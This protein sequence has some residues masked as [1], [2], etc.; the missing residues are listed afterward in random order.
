[1]GETLTLANQR[2]AHG[3]SDIGTYLAFQD[4]LDLVQLVTGGDDLLNRYS[5]IVVNPDMAQGVMIDETDRFIDRISSNETKEFL[6]D[7]GLVVFGQ[8]LFTPLYPPECTEPPYNCTTCS[9][10]MNM[11]A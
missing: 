10:S 3:L 1:M 11:T 4:Q 9:G 5:A 6:G 8:P 7:F 2:E